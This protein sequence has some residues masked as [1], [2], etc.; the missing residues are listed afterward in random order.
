MPRV[1]LKPLDDYL[2][3][4]QMPIRTTDMNYA[5]HLSACA[6][7]GMLDEAYTR[8]LESLGLG[9]MGFGEPN[10]CSINGDLQVNYL[11]EGHLHEMLSMEIGIGEISRKSFRVFHRVTA[12]DRVIALAEVGAVCFDYKSKR[13]AEL[14]EAFIKAVA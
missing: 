4:W 12:K 14:P 8:F 9:E 10:I 6:L 11:S 7:V 2:F 1:V 3:T 13:S 5:N